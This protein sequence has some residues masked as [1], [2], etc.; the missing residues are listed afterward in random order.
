MII[1]DLVI[2]A[3]II[4]GV[5]LVYVYKMVIFPGAYVHQWNVRYIDLVQFLYHLSTSMVAGG[6]AI[7]LTKAAILLDWLHIFVPHRTRNAMAWTIYF[8][9]AINSLYYLAG[10][11]AEIFGCTPRK[12]IWDKTTPG[13]C[14]NTKAGFLIA[15]SFNVVCDSVILALPQKIIWGLNL[16]PAKKIGISSLFAIGIL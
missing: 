10:T 7:G 1:T 2:V 15:A 3:W 16:T 6:T 9:I 8:L 12:K 5:F 14:T 13:T 4:F 11:I